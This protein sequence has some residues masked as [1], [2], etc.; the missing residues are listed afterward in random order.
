MIQTVKV[1]DTGVIIRLTIAIIEIIEDE[2]FVKKERDRRLLQA[3][4]SI[5][6]TFQS[7][8]EKI[9]DLGTVSPA[10][11]YKYRDKNPGQ[12]NYF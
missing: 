4:E 6:N 5:T 8:T 12:A 7:V 2:D 10:T 1:W 3:I 11:P 9:K